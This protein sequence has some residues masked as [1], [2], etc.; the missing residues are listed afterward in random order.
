MHRLRK[1]PPL[2]VEGDAAATADRLDRRSRGEEISAE[3]YKPTAAVLERL[4]HARA[5][6]E[7]ALQVS[8]RTGDPRVRGSSAWPDPAN[9]A[10]VD[11]PR[12]AG[13]PVRP[14][15]A[16]TSPRPREAGFKDS[17]DSVR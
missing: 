10:P 17:K 5:E 2:D 11:A 1:M 13:E 15:R 16:L 9:T 14:E 4:R 6:G 7:A 8:L 3:E 12:A